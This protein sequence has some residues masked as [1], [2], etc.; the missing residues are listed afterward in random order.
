MASKMSLWDVA[1]GQ[2]RPIETSAAL[3]LAFFDGGKTLVCAD[4]Q[5]GPREDGG[6]RKDG[7][8][9]WD[10]A[11]KRIRALPRPADDGGALAFSPDGK[12]FAPS[13]SYDDPT[14]Y[15]WQTA[16]GGLIKRFVGHTR[17]VHCLTFSPDG[18]LVASGSRDTT[19]LLWE[20]PGLR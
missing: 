9:F 1:T 2:E 15:L 6:L 13:G 11:G 18:R 12:V 14:V 3:N 17:E 4:G 8:E 16:I 5:G 19:V 7:M 10:V 20:V